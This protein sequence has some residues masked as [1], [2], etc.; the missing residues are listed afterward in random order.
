[1]TDAKPA[2]P[3]ERNIFKIEGKIF[4]FVNIFLVSS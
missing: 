2:N 4:I 3:P 1:M